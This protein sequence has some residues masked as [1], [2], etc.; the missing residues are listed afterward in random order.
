MRKR[1]ENNKNEKNQPDIE[2]HTSATLGLTVVFAE[3]LHGSPA[4][5][6]AQNEL[7]NDLL[8]NAR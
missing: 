4:D 8:R 6:S 5:H 3:A 7:R 1:R 2:S